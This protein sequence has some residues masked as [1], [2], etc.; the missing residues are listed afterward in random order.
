MNLAIGLT[1]LRILLVPVIIIS[2]AYY[3]GKTE[4]LRLLALGLFLLGCATDAVDGYVARVFH[5]RTEIGTLLDPVADKLLLIG[6][7]LS[8]CFQAHFPIKPPIWVVVLITSRDFLIIMGLLILFFTTGKINVSP[9]F[10]GKIT[11]VFQMMTLVLLLLEHPTVSILWNITALLTVSSG[12]V[13]IVR[14][15]RR[16]RE[17]SVS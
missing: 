13:Y 10:L 16:L 3:D 2:I 6:T 5:Q 15:G 12:L 7:L 8:I 9:N 11:T 17:V 4:S 1:L 14:E